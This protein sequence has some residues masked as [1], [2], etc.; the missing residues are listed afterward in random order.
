MPPGPPP[1]TLPPRPRWH[2]GGANG[3]GPALQPGPP[4]PLQPATEGPQPGRSAPPGDDE[5]RPIP[6]V[7]PGNGQVRPLRPGPQTPPGQP[8]A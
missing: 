5:T 8:P 2:A 1:A 6:V 7:R 4:A 3:P